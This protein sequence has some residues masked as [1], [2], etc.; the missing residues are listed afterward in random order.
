MTSSLQISPPDH[1]A[2]AALDREPVGDVA[3]QGRALS[4]L[5]DI[6]EE[7]QGREG[8]YGRHHLVGG[9][10]RHEETDGAV[11][12]YEQKHREQPGQNERDVHM[13][14]HHGHGNE[15]QGEDHDEE[16]GDEDHRQELAADDLEAAHGRGVE[17]L[18]R[19]GGVFAAHQIHRQQRDV[20]VDRRL[21][22][23]VDSL[24]SED[25]AGRDAEGDGVS[26][27]LDLGDRRQNVRE[28]DTHLAGEDDQQQPRYGGEEERGQFVAGY[29]EQEFSIHASVV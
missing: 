20:E 18:D 15:R 2:G 16:Q 27:R 24:E 8:R 9:Q 1:L 28:V 25:H 12:E 17:Q 19:T 11:G 22:D 5:P 6:V 4:D 21:Y 7:G 13:G 29:S 26:E 3:D 14:D 23:L 10:R